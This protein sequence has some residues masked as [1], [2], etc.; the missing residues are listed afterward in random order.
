[1]EESENSD[2]NYS[3]NQTFNKEKNDEYNEINSRS[4]QSLVSINYSKNSSNNSNNLEDIIFK[5]LK[6]HEQSFLNNGIILKK[7]IEG[8]NPNTKR[9]KKNSLFNLDSNSTIFIWRELFV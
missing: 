2:N 3:L 9:A 4:I 6:E 1:M 8:S 5:E 7:R